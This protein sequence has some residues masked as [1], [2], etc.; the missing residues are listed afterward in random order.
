MFATTLNATCANTTDVT[1]AIVAAKTSIN[2]D[3]NTRRLRI[4]TFVSAGIW[5]C[6]PPAGNRRSTGRRKG[7]GNAAVG[8][9]W[10]EVMKC[11]PTLFRNE[12]LQQSIKRECMAS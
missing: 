3:A 2:A 4:W 12:R 8:V 6:G 7:G 11:N 1:A 9:S 5:M 10:G